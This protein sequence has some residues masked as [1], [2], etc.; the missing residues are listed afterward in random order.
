VAARELHHVATL[1][2][3]RC[4]LDETELVAGHGVDAVR[5]HGAQS[6]TRHSCVNH[7][8]GHHALCG[9]RWR[10]RTGRP[11]AALLAGSNWAATGRS[12]P[13]RTM[14]GRATRREQRG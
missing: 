11:P 6:R 3:L 7:P 8:F 2:I 10:A 1:D 12:V 9:H 14:Q 13:G 5:R 4:M